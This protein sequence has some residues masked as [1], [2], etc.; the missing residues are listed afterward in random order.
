MDSISAIWPERPPNNRLQ[1]FISVPIDLSPVLVQTSDAS[2][3]DLWPAVTL[4]TISL[5]VFERLG[6]VGKNKM[7]RLPG[8]EP[9]FLINFRAKVA[10]RR[11]IE[12]GT[13]VSFF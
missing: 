6:T 10:Q 8:S 11:W 5:Q 12:S 4:N 9:D 1:V 7:F 3:R 13:E 2:T